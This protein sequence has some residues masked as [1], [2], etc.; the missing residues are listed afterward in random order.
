MLRE[1]KLLDLIN[2][3]YFAPSGAVLRVVECGPSRAHTCRGR[4][5]ERVPT[6]I[7][8]IGEGAP[9][10]TWRIAYRIFYPPN[11]AIDIFYPPYLAKVYCREFGVG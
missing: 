3:I 8:K 1:D 2:S 11:L 10:T 6:K 4:V 5:E 9:C 7:K